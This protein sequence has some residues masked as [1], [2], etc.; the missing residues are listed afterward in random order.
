MQKEPKKPKNSL[1]NY[2]KKFYQERK[3]KKRMI[4]VEVLKLKIKAHA[5]K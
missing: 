3:A 2:L 1:L 5:F 4:R